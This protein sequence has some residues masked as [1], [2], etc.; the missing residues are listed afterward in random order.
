MPITY[1][2]FTKQLK[3]LPI[4]LHPDGGATVS[5]R[6]GFVGEDNVWTPAEER[7]INLQAAAVASILDQQP[8]AGLSRH[9]DLA[10]AVYTHLVTNGLVPAGEIS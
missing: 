8:T 10:A 7:Q 4:T 1:G 3:L 6:Y 5:V 9:D 2:N